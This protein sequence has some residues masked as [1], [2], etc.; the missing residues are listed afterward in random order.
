MD[1]R[2]SRIALSLDLR[3]VRALAIALSVGAFARAA[4]EPASA[5]PSQPLAPEEL[6]DEHSAF[7]LRAP[8]SGWRTMDA[9]EFSALDPEAAAGLLHDE[10][11]AVAYL[12]VVPWPAGTLARFADHAVS[13][14][15]HEQGERLLGPVSRR[16]VQVPGAAE[17]LHLRWRARDL[18]DVLFRYELL[19]ARRATWYYALQLI[20]AE[21]ETA[22]D[23]AMLARFDEA[24][25]L[26][27]ELEPR[28]RLPAHAERG[29]D[30]ESI[31]EGGVVR[32]LAS[33]FSLRTPAGYRL[34]DRGTTF[35][36]HGA[37]ARFLAED[38][39]MS[40][41]AHASLR[42]DEGPAAL[43]DIPLPDDARSSQRELEI[44]GLRARLWTRAQPLLAN[45]APD[46]ATAQA[47]LLI[48]GPTHNLS[49]VA[50]TRAHADG[51]RLGATLLELASHVA[52]LDDA[53]RIASLDELAAR[54]DRD[55]DL[56]FEEHI[57]TSCSLRLGVFEDFEHGFRL[58]RPAGRW[59]WRMSF[60][61][62]AS[63]EAEEEDEEWM[64]RR[65]IWLQSLGL[66]TSAE[67][68]VVRSTLDEHAF[69]GSFAHDLASYGSVTTLEPVH[70]LEV[71]G[72]SFLVESC[73]L[74]SEEESEESSFWTSGR[75]LHASTRL[76]DELYL[77]VRLHG[78]LRDAT[79]IDEALRSILTGLEID[80]T[81]R[82]SVEETERGWIDRRVGF[83]FEAVAE[84]WKPKREEV[85]LDEERV[86]VRV[87]A[88]G[89]TEFVL[90]VSHFPDASPAQRA[91][92]E[93]DQLAS[94]LEELGNEGLSVEPVNAA[95]REDLVSGLPVRRRL[96]GLKQ[97]GRRA[98]S[99]ASAHVI[100]WQLWRGCT[101]FTLVL[102]EYSGSAAK[103]RY[104]DAV[105]PGFQLLPPGR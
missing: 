66:G 83:R 27:P 102:L 10:S 61:E 86:A 42:R 87:V 46:Q 1:R 70:E 89:L 92:L 104:A 56:D 18:D 79:Q 76:R 31:V 58:R 67:I 63:D 49:F 20:A 4:Q 41:N 54:R 105:L 30:L 29:E 11:G 51:A 24:L 90:F 45:A 8:A 88:R 26:L 40:C 9:L 103:S 98:K 65:W 95:T 94:F 21:P 23:T 82:A 33:G 43:A 6:V 28:P 52:V 100:S 2:L 91:A 84:R 71:G 13:M 35:L 38:G 96:H 73:E 3:F 7:A 74:L 57:G 14:V 39:L 97:T 48:H 19:L 68:S 59:A 80:A 69:Q 77:C 50:E 44:A 53:Q 5:A 78:A 37:V 81:P 25:R 22:N 17:A 32:H 93:Q 85:E 16:A 34:V 47:W 99:E 72:R 36:E 75:Y 101:C 62:G 55:P 60:D 12:R 64:P 15:E